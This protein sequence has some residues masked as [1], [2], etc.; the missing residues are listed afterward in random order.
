MDR[1]PIRG[2]CPW[3]LQGRRLSLKEK[4]ERSAAAA[5]A[6]IGTM[7]HRAGEEGFLQCIGQQGSIDL[8]GWLIMPHHHW[9]PARIIAVTS[10]WNFTHAIPSSSSPALAYDDDDDD[11]DDDD[12]S[13]PSYLIAITAFQLP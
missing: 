1:V 11:D 2:P 4:P 5:A 13:A 3:P 6:A 8:D 7:S 9:Q 10:R 12:V